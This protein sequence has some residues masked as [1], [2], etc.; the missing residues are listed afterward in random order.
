MYTASKTA[1]ALLFHWAIAFHNR[2]VV[3]INIRDLT[4][5]GRQRDGQNK[6]LQIN[7]SKYSLWYIINRMSLNTV[8]EVEDVGF[9]VGKSSAKP[10][11]NLHLLRLGKAWNAAVVSRRENL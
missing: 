7:G 6:L 3:A 8:L 4:I 9:M 11:L 2:T 5:L 1:G 10:S